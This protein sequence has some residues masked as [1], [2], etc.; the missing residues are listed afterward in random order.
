MYLE[1]SGSEMGDR[2]QFSDDRLHNNWNL[3]TMA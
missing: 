3:L 2:F 1:V